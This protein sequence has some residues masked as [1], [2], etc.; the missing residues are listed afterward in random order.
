MSLVCNM[1]TGGSKFS[2]EP[3]RLRYVYE[4]VD[5]KHGYRYYGQRYVDPE[6]PPEDDGYLGSPGVGNHWRKVVSESG[7]S[8]ICKR[9]LFVGNYLEVGEL[10]SLVI[11]EAWD[12]Y[13]KKAGELVRRKER[14]SHSGKWQGIRQESLPLFL[15][16]RL[17]RNTGIKVAAKRPS[18]KRPSNS[19]GHLD[20]NCALLTKDQL[21]R[22]YVGGLHR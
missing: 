22:F 13:G 17:P 14:K 1:T 8:D 11:R 6:I 10:E 20:R 2:D 21:S 7:A 4:L 15:R 5:R 9:V 16:R 18:N 19:Y 3:N 12:K